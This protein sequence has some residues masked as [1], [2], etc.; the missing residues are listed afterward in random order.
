MNSDSVMPMQESAPA[1]GIVVPQM[2]E[3]QGEIL[4]GGSATKA[5]IVRPDAFV[6]R[7]AR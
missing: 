2:N 4:P 6:I 7:A 3:T 5:P 1:E